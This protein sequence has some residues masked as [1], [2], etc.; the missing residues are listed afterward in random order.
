MIVQLIFL[1][2]KLKKIGLFTPAN[3]YVK[4]T[5]SWTD[6]LASHLGIFSYFRYPNAKLL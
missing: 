4:W 5:K 3:I 6:F 2:V 1:K